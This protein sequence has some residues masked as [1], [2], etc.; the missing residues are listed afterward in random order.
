[1]SYAF[2]Q[3]SMLKG[4]TKFF[5]G[6]RREF[7]TFQVEVSTFSSLECQVC[8][9]TVFAEKW[10]FQ[11]MS[12]E[13]F[14]RIRP[15]FPRTRWVSFRGWGDPLENENLLEM[16]RQ[17]KEAESAAALATNG[18][19]LTEEY[20]RQLLRTDPD[21]IV[22]SLELATQAIQD[23]LARIGSDFKR[24]L[25]QVQALV[26]LRK[27]SGGK[28]PA[29]KLSFPMTRLNMGEL[30]GLVPLSA[31]LG[32]DE[33][34]FTNLDYLPEERWNI[35]RTFYHE[36]PTPA[37]QESA[38]EVQRLGKRERI[39]VRVYPLKAEEVPVCE[40]DPP[41]KIFFSVDGSISPC[42]YLRIPK[43]GEIP[44]IFM[45]KEYAVPQIIFGNANQEN[46]PEVW[47][48]ESYRAFR[49]IFEERKRAALNM[50]QLLDSFSNLR[51]G[52]GTQPS[53]EPPPPLSEACRTCYKA[54]G[55]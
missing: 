6:D 54:Y 22:V 42:Q 34:I 39:A 1:M 18:S 49:K 14:Q 15:Y 30:P 31:K 9:R 32:V 12:L 23:S 35:L 7:E 24:I 13:T 48:K 44:R 45:N 17:V 2:L 53:P 16:V 41:Q 19:L 4:L 10:V 29:I 43:R 36:S 20:S 47:A 5:L 25:D 37:F 28:K 50:G 8:A 11:N 21:L 33:V 40:A 52:M 46:F 55:I 51:S 27:E 3:V 26:K 38:N